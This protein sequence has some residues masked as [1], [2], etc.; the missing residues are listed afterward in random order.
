M[1]RLRFLV[2]GFPISAKP[3]T[4]INSLE[5]I[6]ELG[7]DGMEIRFV[8]GV[9]FDMKMMA[10]I[11]SK[12]RELS[13]TLTAHA[14][15]EINFNDK[16]KNHIDK[17]YTLVLNAARALDVAGGYSLVFHAGEYQ[18]ESS[19]F[20]YPRIRDH[21]RSLQS[22]LR[23]ESIRIWIRPEVMGKKTQFGTVYELI[24][25]AEELQQT[26]LPCI[27]ISHWH[28]RTGKNNTYEEFERLLKLLDKRL[29]D[30][31]VKN[32]HLH[33]SGIDYTELGENRHIILRKSDFKYR[34]FLKS[35]Y[36]YGICGVLV[37]ESPNVEG[38]ALLL[39]SVYESF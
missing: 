8:N 16:D 20:V 24:D 26:V 31:A 5:R 30:D 27:D 1:D 34:E 7:L 21:I 28:A 17:S 38:D 3:R 10:E 6:K 32:I 19:Q 36:D 2:S 25:L 4:P 29:G 13:L 35:L 22:I 37:C 23:K 14:P 18:R 15:Y 12:A 39:K 33:L 9:C 11:G